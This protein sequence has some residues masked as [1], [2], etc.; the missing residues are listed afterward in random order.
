MISEKNLTPGLYK[1]MFILSVTVWALAGVRIGQASDLTKVNLKGTNK[2]MTSKITRVDQSRVM[3][4]EGQT[5]AWRMEGLT[6]KLKELSKTP[7]KGAY[8]VI[9]SPG[10]S[11]M[12]GQ[13]FINA[14]QAAK[15]S[16]GLKVTC[17]ITGTAYSMAAV[18]MSYCLRT[19]ALPTAHIMFH[20]ASYGVQGPARQV[21]LAVIRS[22]AMLKQWETELS[23]QL[24]ISYAQYKALT[25]NELWM[26]I[27]VAVQHGFVDGKI[28][29]FHYT[30]EP[31]KEPNGL[32]FLF[33]STD[34]FKTAEEEGF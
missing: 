13:K 10:G 8:L 1:R 2:I 14:M 7:A 16:T 24:R 18:I 20:E 4:L 15:A 5:T 11:I 31:E 26:T 22:E 29:T 32:G 6:K 19:L 33:G 21:K 9:D 30:V 27:D 28:S 12:A 17:I 34:Y 3:V 25:F 23:K